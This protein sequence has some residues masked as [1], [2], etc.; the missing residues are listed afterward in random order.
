MLLRT[1]AYG[2]PSL[3]HPD[4]DH[5]GQ[6]FWLSA[7][8]LLLW[9][10]HKAM[11]FQFCP[12]RENSFLRLKH[13]THLKA[14]D[15]M[16]NHQGKVLPNFYLHLLPLFVNVQSPDSSLIPLPAFLATS[17]FPVISCPCNASNCLSP[18]LALSPSFLLFVILIIIW[19]NY[20]LFQGLERIVLLTLGYHFTFS[21][22]YLQAPV[23]RGGPT[24]SSFELHVPTTSVASDLIPQLPTS[25]LIQ[26]KTLFLQGWACSYTTDRPESKAMT[27]GNTSLEMLRTGRMGLPVS[28]KDLQVDQ[29][30]CAINLDLRI[31]ERRPEDF[32][33]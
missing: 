32:R 19:Y 29:I 2:F 22:I 9:T 7:S 30:K 14:E 10:P 27:D 33:H 4:R 20:L 8:R 5:G 26:Q 31:W 6:R 21:L 23:E 12:E 1:G 28:A 15:N 3:L 24:Q 18:S 13:P 11:A 25:S 16:F 17:L